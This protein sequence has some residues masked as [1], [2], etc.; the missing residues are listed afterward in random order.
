MISSVVVVV[1]RNPNITT[2]TDTLI[3]PQPLTDTL[4]TRHTDNMITMNKNG[5]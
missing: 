5:T 1:A 4:K 2:P 3:T